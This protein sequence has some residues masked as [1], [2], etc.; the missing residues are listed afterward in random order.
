MATG[1][2]TLKEHAVVWS[3]IWV[4][5]ESCL[6]G[7]LRRMTPWR[8]TLDGTTVCSYRVEHAEG[9]RCS[10]VSHMGYPQDLIPAEATAYSTLWQYAGEGFSA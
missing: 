6:Q 5:L 3:H 1:H 8:E 4:T 2:N 10:I 7:V 9:T